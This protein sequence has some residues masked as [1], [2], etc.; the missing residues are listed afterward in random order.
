MFFPSP[1]IGRWWTKLPT[2]FWR[3]RLVRPRPHVKY[4]RAIYP[5]IPDSFNY[6]NPYCSYVRSLFGITLSASCA[7]V[8]I[9]WV[10]SAHSVPACDAPNALCHR[11]PLLNHRPWQLTPPGC[12]LC[13]HP[14]LERS[15]HPH[16][17]PPCL[18]TC[19]Q[20]PQFHSLILFRQYLI[21]FGSLPWSWYLL[22]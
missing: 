11:F 2:I 20:S 13:T 4:S 22:Q 18:L 19:L 7:K 21:L 6:S 3:I 10:C 1:P 9:I 15:H 12:F 5:N 8:N 14:Y 16:P 17:H